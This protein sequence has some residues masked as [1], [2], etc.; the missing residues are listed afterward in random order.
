MKQLINNLVKLTDEQKKA[1]GI[2]LNKTAETAEEHHTDKD[3][4]IKF[5]ESLETQL[6]KGIERSK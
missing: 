1:L 4:Y 2:T 6:R 5:L 3:S